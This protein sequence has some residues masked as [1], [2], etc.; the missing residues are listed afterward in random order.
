M[1]F[2]SDHDIP[3]RDEIREASSILDGRETARTYIEANRD[4]FE[5]R[6]SGKE[7]VAVSDDGDPELAA[8]YDPESD[9][10]WEQ[11]LEQI[12]DVYGEGYFTAVARV[13]D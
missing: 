7:I 4:Y 3:G 2:S 5:G 12:K 10:N 11:A 6:Y 13:M 8:A 9:H 1:D